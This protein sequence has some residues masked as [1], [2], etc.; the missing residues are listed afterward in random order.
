MN[1]PQPRL[2]LSNGQPET[3]DV[4]KMPLSA[5]D[6]VQI[7]AGIAAVRKMLQQIERDNAESLLENEKRR[8]IRLRAPTEEQLDSVYAA[9]TRTADSFPANSAASESF[10]EEA[11]KFIREFQTYEKPGRLLMIPTG[12]PFSAKQLDIVEYAEANAEVKIGKNGAIEINSEQTSL[13]HLLEW[14]VPNSHARQRYGHLFA[15]P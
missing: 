2:T 14:D 11:L 12:D 15:N 3:A 6:Q 13:S 10:R 7:A 5:D 1:G 9:L 4:A 8:F